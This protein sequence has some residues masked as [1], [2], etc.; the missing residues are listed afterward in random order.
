MSKRRTRTRSA[1]PKPTEPT[2][3]VDGVQVRESSIL[4]AAAKLSPPS[5]SNQGRPVN[6]CPICYDGYGGKGREKWRRPASGTLTRINYDCNQCGH[7]W[8]ADVRT[9]RVVEAV[10]WKTAEL[11]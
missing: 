5:G 9:V 10:N 8:S 11:I 2:I 1:A 3:V 4:K 6:A 7:N